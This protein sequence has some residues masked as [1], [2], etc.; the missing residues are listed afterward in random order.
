MSGASAL[1][2]FQSW[3]PDVILLDI[4]LPDTTGWRLLDTL[5][6][7][8]TPEDNPSVIIVTALSDAVNR[9]T[10][11][12]QDVQGYLIKPFSI[13]QVRHTVTNLLTQRAED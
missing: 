1:A 3:H 8:A 11:R 9:V 4:E 5:R 13:D 10:G 12:I 6:S 7:V 2:T